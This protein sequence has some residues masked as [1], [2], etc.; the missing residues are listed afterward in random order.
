M[1]ML[2]LVSLT[3]PKTEDFVSQFSVYAMLIYA[4]L[5]PYFKQTDIR[6]IFSSN[7][8]QEGESQSVSSVLYSLT[9]LYTFITT[10]LSEYFEHCLHYGIN[11]HQGVPMTL[12]A[13]KT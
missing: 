6:T 4:N 13:T 5:L 8:G 1:N 12:N 3:Y 2:Y 10:F 11:P 9:Y 7:C